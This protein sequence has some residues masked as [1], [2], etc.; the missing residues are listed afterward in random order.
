MVYWSVIVILLFL[1][2]LFERFKYHSI[3]NLQQIEHPATAK[4]SSDPAE[5][6]VLMGCHVLLC[7]ISGT[8]V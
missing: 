2:N 8:F 1:K 6:P 4:V 5:V 3:T 7:T